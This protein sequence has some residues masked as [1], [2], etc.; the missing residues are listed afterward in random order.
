MAVKASIIKRHVD[1]S[2]HKSGK[3]RL[4]QKEKREATILQ[5]MKKYDRQVHPEGEMLSD[6]QRV[7]RVKVVKTFLKAGVPL[8]KLDIFR[9]LLEEGGYRLTTSPHIRQII[10]FIRK[11]EERIRSEIAGTNVA[12]IFDGITRLGEALAVVL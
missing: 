5:A 2:K 4:A 8:N 7:Y 3:T 6:N 9:E 11:E 10:P 12:V 1:S